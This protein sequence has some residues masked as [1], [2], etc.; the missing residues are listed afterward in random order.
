MKTL[1]LSALLIALAS[2]FTFSSCL[3]DSDS[4]SLPSYSSYVTI[5]GDAF[6]GY[7][8]H[9]DFGCTLKPTLSSVEEVLPG[10]SS[11]TAKRA[12]VAFDLA[13]ESLNGQTL[14]AGKTYDI[15]L[16]SSYYANY[17]IP[18]YQTIDITDDTAAAD[19][20]T[21]NNHN[22]NTVNN[23]I[24]A[25]N[26]YVNVQLTIDYDY[27]KSFYLNTY[28]DRNTDI[29]VANNT[30]YLN[31][32]YNP[33]STTPTSQGSSVFSFELPSD[34]AYEFQG[35]SVDIVLRA[36][37]NNNTQ[38]EEVGKCSMKVNDFYTPSYY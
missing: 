12:L 38:L 6:F 25:I 20:L 11:S 15:I 19:S 34:A 30:L 32:Y 31:L 28:Y 33:N 3:D 5:T 35:E 13:D 14:E 4:S 2:V 22:I 29:D 21:T 7:V 36:F 1:K 27:N 23:D 37:T 9:S 16:R 18:T 24:W 17:A 26:G 8:F 10:L